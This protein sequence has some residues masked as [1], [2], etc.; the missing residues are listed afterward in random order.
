MG[1]YDGINYL[2]IVE[3]YNLEIN[4]WICVVFMGVRRGG[5]GVVI[6]GGC[7]YVIGGYDGIFNF[8]ILG[9]LVYLYSYL[10]F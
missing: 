4:V 3:K 6:F 5:V 10:W 1:G 9:N 8:S 2:K 7:L